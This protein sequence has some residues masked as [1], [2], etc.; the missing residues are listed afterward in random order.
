MSSSGSDAVAPDRQA[1]DPR[2]L[3]PD[4]PRRPERSVDVCP[5]GLSPSAGLTRERESG[6]PAVECAGV[7][8]GGV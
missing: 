4:G 7:G 6:V 8:G 3:T 2:P 5:S 1:P